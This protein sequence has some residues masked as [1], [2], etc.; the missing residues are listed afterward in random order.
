MQTLGPEPFRDPQRR[1]RAE[2]LNKA[3]EAGWAGVIKSSP[4]HG[5]RMRELFG[6]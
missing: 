5:P 4:Q 6:K 3:Y 2:F 1:Q